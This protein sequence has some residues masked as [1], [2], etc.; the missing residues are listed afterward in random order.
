MRVAEAIRLGSL[1]MRPV[2]G[3]MN[4]RMGGGCALG[5]AFLALGKPIGRQI[6]DEYPWMGEPKSLHDLP[7][8]CSLDKPIMLSGGRYYNPEYGPYHA[9]IGTNVLVVH[10]FNYHVCTTKDWTIDRLCE[11]LDSVDPTPRETESLT[12]QT[13]AEV[14]QTLKE[15]CT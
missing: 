5:M 1:V 11:W 8:S 13:E 12:E 4:D 6:A 10:L 3:N 2:C 7:C 9:P 14:H 15:V